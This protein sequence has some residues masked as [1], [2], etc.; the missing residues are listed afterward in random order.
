MYRERFRERVDL[1][2]KFAAL[3]CRKFAIESVNLGCSLTFNIASNSALM[4]SGNWVSGMGIFHFLPDGPLL[5]SVI[6][7]GLALYLN[8][9][10]PSKLRH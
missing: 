4:F 9:V 10:H 3:Y 5:M 7:E 2:G 1:V 6:P 8:T